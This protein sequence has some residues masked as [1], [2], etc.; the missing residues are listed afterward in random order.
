[1]NREQITETIKQYLAYKHAVT[2]YE[3]HRPI[4][5]AG[6]ASYNAMP[7]GSGAPERFFAI[8]GKPADMGMTSQ[9]DYVDYTRYKTAVTELEGAFGVLT[10]EELSVIKLKWM[11]DVTLKQIAD[12]KNCSVDTVKSRHK[13]AINKLSDALR[14]AQLPE[15][16]THEYAKVDSF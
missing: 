13:R 7:S 8:V 6:V 12:R 2:M 10:E 16:Q 3:R 15:I 11:H 1:M 14:F 5:S 9:A 4:P